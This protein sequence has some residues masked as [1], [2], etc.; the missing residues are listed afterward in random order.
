MVQVSTSEVAGRTSRWVPFHAGF[1]VLVL[2][3]LLL[4]MADTGPKVM[5]LVIAYNVAVPVL[6]RRTDD[7]ALW[8]TWA[9][10]APMSVLMVLP[11]WF[12][13]AVL[14]TLEFPNTGAPYIGTMPLFMAGMWTIALLPLMMIGRQV[15]ATRGPRDAFVAVGV[16][17]LA[18]FIAAE[19]LAPAIPLWEPV[20][21]AQ[22]L[23]IAVY[24]LLPELALCIAS[25]ELVRGAR[26]RP[27]V[28]TVGGIIAVPFMY[29]GML[30]T[31]YQ[32]LG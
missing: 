5:A 4:P 30:A 27:W 28:A 29:L 18:L 14:G 19:W 2:A 13:S 11:D 10:L 1:A 23:G 6:A 22:V 26:R 25:Y 3:V 32:F 16:A 17:G 8:I 21:A 7:D 9:V 12:L 15:E 20:G 24:V 31:G